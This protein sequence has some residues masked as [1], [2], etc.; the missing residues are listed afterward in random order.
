MTISIQLREQISRIQFTRKPIDLQDVTT[1]IGASQVPAG[2]PRLTAAELGVSSSRM[3]TTF[4]V[5]TFPPIFLMDIAGQLVLV[6]TEGGNY[7][8]YVTRVVE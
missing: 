1:A 6:N 4:T 8:R 3:L 5:A 2:L 7:C